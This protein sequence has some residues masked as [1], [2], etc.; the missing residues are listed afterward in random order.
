M[1]TMYL[2]K[3]MLNPVQY[4]IL[5]ASIL[6][7]GTLAKITKKSRR[8][9]SN[10]RESFGESQL[11][12]REWKVT[13]LEGLLYFN[14]TKSEVL[15]R[16]LPLFTE[17]EKL[18]YDTNRIKHIPDEILK[19]CTLPHF[20]ATLYMDDGSL[21]ISYRVN[22]NFK[23]IYLT[24]H[25]PLYLQSFSK[26]DLELLRNHMIEHF[27]VNLTLSKRKDGFGYVLKT[28]AVDETFKFL[29][30]TRPAILTCLSMFYKTNWNYRFTKEV[31][32]YASKYPKYEV[33][34]SSGERS[35][36]YSD[37]EIELLIKL[38]LIRYTDKDVA[39]LL[40]RSYWSVVYKWKEIRKESVELIAK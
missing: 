11:G 39:E 20:L 34:T 24:P 12:Y 21:S 40:N 26:S 19:N 2:Y 8:I 37:D 32:K 30:A 15:S 13:L 38:K 25:I 6:G 23:K 17:L 14:K 22:H 33:I 31:I 3:S 5:L 4:N 1:R 27:K 28:T 18:F 9:N 16:S 29:R 10:Y 7:D 35:K 36:A